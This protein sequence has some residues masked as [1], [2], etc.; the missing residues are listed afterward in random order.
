VLLQIP[1]LLQSNTGNVYD[2]GAQSDRNFGELA[3]E[4]LGAEGH[5]ET[6]QVLVQGKQS[7][8]AV[9][10]LSVG[11][12]LGESA[13]CADLFILVNGLRVKCLDFKDIEGDSATV[14]SACPLGIL[15]IRCQYRT[16]A[17]ECFGGEV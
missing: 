2:I 14:A 5:V 9:W 13:G 8:E 10:R 7:Q 11:F 3:V 1:E 4:E 6:G 17:F 12:G 16:D 15:E